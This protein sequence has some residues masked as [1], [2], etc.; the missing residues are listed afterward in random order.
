MVLV[1]FFGN[2]FHYYMTYYKELPCS[3]FRYRSTKPITA[4]V[5]PC[6]NEITA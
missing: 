5:W 6:S 4:R 3:N 2:N 1:K